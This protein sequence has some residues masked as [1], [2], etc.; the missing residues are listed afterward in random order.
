MNIKRITLIA[1]CIVA[2]FFVGY[3][4][5]TYLTL[6]WVSGFMFEY[7]DYKNVSL[8]RPELYE[9]IIRVKGGA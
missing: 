7:L 5:A 2:A 6:E 3:L 4:I 9:Y 1:A 8:S